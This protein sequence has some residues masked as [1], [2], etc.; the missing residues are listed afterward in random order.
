MEESAA[1]LFNPEI[2]REL[3]SMEMPYGKIQRNHTLASSR[4]LC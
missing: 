2:L 1:H 3:V 4:K